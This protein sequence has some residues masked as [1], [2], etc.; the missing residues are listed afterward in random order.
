VR[1]A[2]TRAL[3]GELAGL[4]ASVEITEPDEVRAE[5]ARLGVELVATYRALVS[6]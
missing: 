5:L 1:G 4:G 2:H 3:A 6:D